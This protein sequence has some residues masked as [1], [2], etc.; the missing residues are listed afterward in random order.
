MKALYAGSFDP[1][2]LGHQNIVERSLP[3]CETL[4]IGIGYNVAKKG[5]YT[6]EKRKEQI[7]ALYAD[8]PK[9]KVVIYDTLTIDLAQEIQAD[10]LIRS[11]RSIQDFESEQQIAEVNKRLSGIETWILFADAHLSCISSSVVREL[12]HFNK[13]ISSFLPKKKKF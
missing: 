11:V 3:F 5:L 10:C 7:E 8:N 2:T 6:V 13:D 4:T 1:F 12:H 9:V